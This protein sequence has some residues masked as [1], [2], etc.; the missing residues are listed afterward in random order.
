PLDRARPLVALFDRA[1]V[2]TQ[3]HRL[4]RA[5][6]RDRAVA[7]FG[8]RDLGGVSQRAFNRHSIRVTQL[9]R[10]IE[11]DPLQRSAATQLL[12]HGVHRRAGFDPDRPYAEPGDL[13][14]LRDLWKSI[15]PPG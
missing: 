10:R 8:A 2:D 13:Q 1:S 7:S 9:S 11:L 14:P 12:H 4:L 15:E 3:R 5:D 6:L